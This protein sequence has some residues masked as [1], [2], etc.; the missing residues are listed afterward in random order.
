[1]TTSLQASGGRELEDETPWGAD[2]VGN[3]EGCLAGSEGCLAGGEGVGGGD[4]ASE[5]E[6]E[7]GEG[8]QVVTEGILTKVNSWCGSL[9]KFWFIEE[10][11]MLLRLT[12][13]LVRIFLD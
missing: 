2:G 13:P 3:S 10:S 1:M 12:F 5:G 11:V 7:G 4:S 6:D 9:K 8:V